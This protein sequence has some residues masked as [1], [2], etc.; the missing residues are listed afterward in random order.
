MHELL[1]GHRGER[2][3]MRMA[4]AGDDG[5]ELARLLVHAHDRLAI[6]QVDLHIARRPAGGDDFMPALQRIDSGLAE[7]ARGTNDQHTHYSFSLG[8]LRPLSL[9]KTES[10]SYSS[11]C[12]FFGCG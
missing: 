8:A 5:I 7:R 6:E 11:S 9:A 2:A 4:G 1:V 10:A 12:G 3:E